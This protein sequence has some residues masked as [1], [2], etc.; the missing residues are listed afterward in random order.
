MC[1]R[2]S[3]YSPQSVHR[4]AFT[5]L[6]CW[7][8]HGSTSA[9]NSRGWKPAPEQC[10]HGA[11][12]T[13]GTPPL[14]GCGVSDRRATHRCR[15]CRS[16]GFRQHNHTCRDCRPCVPCGGS[17]VVR[18]RPCSCSLPCPWLV[19]VSLDR[20]TT[21]SHL[22]CLDNALRDLVTLYFAGLQRAQRGRENSNA[23]VDGKA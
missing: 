5:A 9:P 22:E 15:P 17:I 11:T 14:V 23:L 16:G 1:P 19:A 21:V 13:I 12:A 8:T 18:V 3:P 4:A 7:H 6:R 10:R 2:V 20:A